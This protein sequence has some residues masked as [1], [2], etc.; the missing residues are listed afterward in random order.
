[1]YHGL[2]ASSKGT[3][4]YDELWIDWN[5]DG[6]FDDSE[7]GNVVGR[8][9]GGGC[10]F[11]PSGEPAGFAADRPLIFHVG[12]SLETRP[13]I[14]YEGT[15]DP[16]GKAFP[17]RLVDTSFD[18]K[19]S[20]ASG[21]FTPSD[22]LVADYDGDGKLESTVPEDRSDDDSE[23]VP[24]T[25]SVL[26][27]DGKY[28]FASV[29]PDSAELTLRPDPTPTGRVEVGSNVLP[30]ALLSQGQN[31]FS[32]PV[33]GGAW[34]L[35]AGTYTVYDARYTETSADGQKWLIHIAGF[36]GGSQ[37]IDVDPARP[38][39]F[40]ACGPYQMSIQRNETVGYEML[41]VWV[42][43]RQGTTVCPIQRADGSLPPQ[44]RIKVTDDRGKSLF[45]ATL[46]SFPVGPFWSAN[47]PV[48][49]HD[50]GPFHVVATWDLPLFG[51]L[52]AKLD[53]KR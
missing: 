10:I 51:H 23:C 25:P 48:G 27:P 7:R 52:S 2:L 4:D 21:M 26:M 44:G 31:L 1:P 35:K 15:F 47:M 36:G 6:W 39:S 37:P 16:G 8:M 20:P 19:F 42:W 45:T 34:I 14:A 32:V 29:S 46:G 13:G 53:F 38:V 18:G 9:R 22:T 49:P 11:E 30:K 24:F 17:I 41:M 5:R 12:S 3:K 33:I 43:N 50:R 40:E 28:Y